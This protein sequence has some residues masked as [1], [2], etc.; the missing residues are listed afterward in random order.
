MPSL[1]LQYCLQEAIIRGNLSLTIPWMVEY[2]SQLDV[3]SL[4]IPYYSRLLEMLYCI[5]RISDLDSFVNFKQFMS[6]KTSVLIK[7]SL[8]WLF[9]LPNFPTDL[10]F[11]CQSSHTSKKLK[12]ICQMKDQKME[13]SV[14]TSKRN[15]SL[16]KLDIIDDGVLY[17]CCPFLTEFKILLTTGNSQTINS[18]SNRHITPVSSQLPNAADS[19]NKKNLEVIPIFLKSFNTFHREISFPR[20]VSVRGSFLSWSA[21]FH[22]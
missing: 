15:L 6:E 7:F 9:E 8:G 18:K 12:T 17:S 20:L 14:S 21:S 11:S 4:R 22:S 3:A 2:L 16:D 1:D 13:V 10:Y 19:T 5:Y